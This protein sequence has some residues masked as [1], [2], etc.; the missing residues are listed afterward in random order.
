[1]SF[2]NNKLNFIDIILIKKTIKFGLF[3]EEAGKFG[4]FSEK[5]G[6]FWFYLEKSFL[7]GK[8]ASRK[9]K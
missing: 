9:Y 4:F 1:M 7:F 6:R 3:E 5:T 2:S 8:R